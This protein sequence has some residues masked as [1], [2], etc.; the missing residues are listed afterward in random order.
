MRVLVTMCAVALLSH[1]AVALDVAQKKSQ[2]PSKPSPGQAQSDKKPADNSAPE[3]KTTETATEK[4]KPSE[5]MKKLAHLIG[6]RWQ[7]EEKYELSPFTPQGGEAK[8]TDMVH[9]GPGGLSVVSNYSSSGTLGENHGVGITTWS[10]DEGIYKQFWVDNFDAAGQFWTGKWEGESLVFTYTQK[11]GDQ[12]FHWKESFSGFS[13]DNFT[14]TFDVG[15]S[16]NDLKRCMTFKFTRI[17]RQSAGVRR[18]GTGMH[19]RPIYDSWGGPRADAT[20][21]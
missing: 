20:Q 2:E 16:E 5:E 9:R 8:G 11:M 14:V 10:A 3:K 19:A 7:V 6:G 1:G 18:H 13:N 17:A 4:P 12:Q 21:H 15:P